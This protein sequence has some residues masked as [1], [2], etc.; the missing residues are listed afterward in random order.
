[1]KHALGEMW[2]GY[3]AAP[4][5]AV[6]AHNLKWELPIAATTGVLIGAVDVP[7]SNHVKSTG[8]VDA[9]D[10]ASNALLGAQL[11]AALLTFAL[12]C[13]HHNGETRSLG[14]TALAGA[15]YALGTDVV[16]KVAFNREYPYKPNGD[17][18]FWA[19]GKSFPSGH[20]SAAF[21]L[22]SAFASRNHRHGWM[23]WTLYAAASS[24]GLLRFPAYKHFPSDIL[25]GGTL[26]Y[27]A[28]RWL[29]EH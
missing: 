29:G 12:G 13:A 16:L 9:A 14:F 7:A 21:G 24:T 28:G 25:I 27:V 5:S 8:V 17:G 4:A 23:N 18:R 19:G 10:T 26:G 15:G 1:L 22:A 6:K 2:R 20:A 11:G 3:K